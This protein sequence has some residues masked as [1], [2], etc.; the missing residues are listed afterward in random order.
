[1][2]ATVISKVNAKAATATTVG[3]ANKAVIAM[4]AGVANKAAT[5]T[6]EADAVVI[7]ALPTEDSVA[8]GPSTTTIGPVPAVAT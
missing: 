3:V 5:E 8:A 7:D 6:I 2:A 1:M 4:T